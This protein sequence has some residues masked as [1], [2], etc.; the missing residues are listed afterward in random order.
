MLGV[1][2]GA[3]RNHFLVIILLA[4]KAIQSLKISWLL[5]G[6]GLCLMLTGWLIWTSL[7]G[8]A[9]WMAPKATKVGA[10]HLL[11]LFF[12]GALALCS[13]APLFSTAPLRRRLLFCPLAALAV[14]V[15]FYGCGFVHSLMYGV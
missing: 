13:I 11:W 9:W 5:F 6:V 2:Y 4:V 12:W 1:Q 14:V 3:R 8:V 10:D 15:A 7:T